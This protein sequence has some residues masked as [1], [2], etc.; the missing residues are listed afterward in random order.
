MAE[1]TGH[2]RKQYLLP[3]S[4][5]LQRAFDSG[6]PIPRSLVHPRWYIH[7]ETLSS[8]SWQP[9]YDKEAETTPEVGRN[10]AIE[11]DRLLDARNVL[12]GEHQRSF[13]R[14]IF[15]TIDKLIRVATSQYIV[16]SLPLLLP[17][18]RHAS[19]TAVPLADKAFIAKRRREQ[20][21][22]A[23]EIRNQR[24][25]AARTKAKEMDTILA[26]SEPDTQDT[27]YS[28]IT[29]RPRSPGYVLSSSDSEPSFDSESLVDASRS[30]SIPLEPLLLASTAPVAVQGEG[31]R[32]MRKRA[33][34]GF[35]NVLLGG[36][37]Q[38]IKKA[39]RDNH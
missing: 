3:C 21:A 31:V 4:H 18:D 33:G 1:C 27:I 32:P 13:D 24:I 25:L 8:K 20:K 14:L 7:G 19:T 2:F 15:D 30:Q 34:T 26:D 38:E 9:T 39:R 11:I 10:M 17:A 37:S 23:K 6:E 22:K 35:Y 36:D 29:I 16:A 12:I 28:H 5:D